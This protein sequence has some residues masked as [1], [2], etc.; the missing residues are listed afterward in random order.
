MIYPVRRPWSTSRQ[1]SKELM[2]M[3]TVNQPLRFS[4]LREET[5]RSD[6]GQ[7]RLSRGILLR[8]SDLAASLL[9][10]L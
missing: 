3:R 7:S 2:E 8:V 6:A 1:F 10:E 5:S 4:A 9:A